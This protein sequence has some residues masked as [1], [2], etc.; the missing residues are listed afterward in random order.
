MVYAN[1]NE[2]EYTTDIEQVQNTLSRVIEKKAVSALVYLCDEY[3]IKSRADEGSDTVITV[4]SGHTVYVQNFD[5][6]SEG[7]IWYQVTTYVNQKEYEG[8]VE[9]KFLAYSDENLIAW[10]NQYLGSVGYS[11]DNEIVNYRDEA[12]IPD[13]VLQFPLS[14]QAALYRL[15]QAHPNWTFVKQDVGLDWSYVIASEIGDKS[16]VPS[17]SPNLWM[18]ANYGSGWAYASQAI[19]EYYMD[20]RN[21]LTESG[22]FQFEQLT[23]NKEYHTEAAVQ[24][25]LNPT[26]MAG[27]VPNE[28]RTYANAIWGSGEMLGVSPFHL[29]SRLYQEQGNGTSPLISGTYPGYEGYYNYFN[30]GA[31]GSSTTAIITSGLQYAK[32]AGWNSRTMSILGGAQVVSK[33]YILKGQDTLYL[34]KFCV[35][36]DYYPLFSHQYMQN[37]IAPTSE[38]KTVRKAYETV[39][40]LENCFVF[41]IPVYA[42]MPSVACPLPGEA[43]GEPEYIMGDEE[44]IAVMVQNFY[45]YILQRDADEAGL[46][47]WVG[48]LVYHQMDGLQAA[49]FFALG[50]E[51]TNRN[52]GNAEFVQAMYGALL[53]RE[54]D[55]AD[56]GVAYW[57]N[58]LDHGVTR[59]YV[60][61]SIGHCQEFLDICTKCRIMVGN[62]TLSENREQNHNVTM[63]VYRCYQYA[64]ERVPD[65]DGLNYWTGEINS[66]RLDARSVA[67]QFLFAEEFL[68]KNLSHEEYVMVLYRMFMGREADENGFM[69]WS[70]VLWNGA[71]RKDVMDAFIGSEE[72]QKILAS[73]GLS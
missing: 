10:E 9:K 52:L 28:G 3:A 57:T 67:G 27:E 11:M 49:G 68:N 50:E 45:K 35:V 51:M 47:H 15:K 61:N 5:I 8:F 48:E 70:A 23:Y 43:P 69:Y 29:A 53:G 46:A 55:I 38:A 13:D 30:V 32:N 66:K 56:S 14:Y 6:D 65:V 39:G 59:A 24:A 64:M 37:I 31:S 36:N 62:L 7:N 19:I 60:V 1:E 71:S 26:F 40:S 2:F 73:F 34:Q 72:F 4:K 25:I 17:S 63:Y 12:G 33:N 16:L 58:M 44:A 18:V 22:I 21:A 41:K 42:N 20:P 54:V